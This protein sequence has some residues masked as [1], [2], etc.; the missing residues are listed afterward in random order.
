MPTQ[1][2]AVLADDS[3]LT[4]LLA[5]YFQYEH[6]FFG[7]FHKDLF[8]DDMIS[9]ATTFCS[10]LSVN[11]VL[12]LA[13]VST[14]PRHK[15]SFQPTQPTRPLDWLGWKLSQQGLVESHQ[16]EPRIGWSW[17]SW[18]SHLVRRSGDFHSLWRAY[19]AINPDIRIRDT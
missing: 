9:G 8:F 15:V 11:A 4:K 10:A 6:Q 12:A 1:W 3:F 7:C 17:M 19:P 13:C 2:T 16:P 14:R 5:L 18:Q